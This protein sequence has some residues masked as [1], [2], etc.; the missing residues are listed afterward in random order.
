MI[1]TKKKD[2]GLLKKIPSLETGR[3]PT[4][5]WLLWLASFLIR[6]TFTAIILFLFCSVL[7]FNFALD[8]GKLNMSIY[9]MSAEAVVNL[10]K[11]FLNHICFPPAKPLQ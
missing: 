11:L 2:D 7:F 10:L 5:G 8:H 3:V 6:V 4:Q 9:R 1:M